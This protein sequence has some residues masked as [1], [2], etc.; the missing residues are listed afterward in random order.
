MH[1]N[2]SFFGIACRAA[3]LS[4]LVAGSAS[5]LQAQQSTSVESGPKPPVFL[6]SESAP[7]DLSSSNS[8]SS[9]SS[10]SVDAA[11]ASDGRFMFSSA[12]LNSSQP[13]PRRRYG[14]PNYSDSH[15]NPDGSPKYA[16]IVGGGLGLPI[17][18]TKKY[19]TPSW[20]LQVGG[21]RNFNKVVGVMAQ[22]D[23]D[24]FGLQGAT[25]ANQEYIYNFCTP[26]QIL[27]G[28]AA[29]VAGLDGNNHVWSFTLNPTFTLPTEGSLGAY[30]V[31]GGGFYHKVTNFTLPTTQCAD[32]FCEFQYS[33]DQNVDHYTSN[34]VGV[35][36]GFGLTYKFSKFSNQR[37]YAEAR[38]VFMDNSQRQGFTAQNVATTTYNG[39]DAYPANSN[40]TTYIPIKVGIRF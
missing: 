32:Q 25:I 13:P 26:A 1:T 39:F 8:S 36:G 34:A 37:F 7:L 31:V 30:V 18:N 40:R 5:L 2:C 19:E 28:C 21:G 22:F 9:S 35:N 6:A 15:S 38:Y 24:N 12:A 4:F 14:R 29:T 11:V 16:F 3:A 33:V 10:S 27:Q 20:G 17:G 23:Y